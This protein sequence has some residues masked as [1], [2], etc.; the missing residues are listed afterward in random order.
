MNTRYI[1]AVD[2]GGSK[3]AVTLADGSGPLIRLSEPTA[4]SGTPRALGE[5]ALALVES[6]CRKSGVPIDAIE[7]L[8]VASCG[9]F[10]RCDG[11]ITLVTPNLCGAQPGAGDLPNDWVR[12]PLEQVL[13]ERF[14]KVE[15]RND[16]V[17]ALVAE[18][19]FGAVQDEPNCV[20]VTWSTGIGMG[21]CVDGRV[22]DGKHG[23]AGHGG[24]MLLTDRS[25]ALC[26]CGNRGDVES[27]ISGRNIGKHYGHSASA[28]FAAAREG[29]AEDRAEAVQ[30]A[31]WFGRALYNMIAILDTQSFV[32]GGSVWLHHG[33][34]LLPFVREEIDH[35]LLTLTKNVS[36]V[37][38]ALGTLVADIGGLCLVMPPAWVPSWRSD[39]PWQKLGTS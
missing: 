19:T 23:N 11:M 32:V 36:I 38:A 17:A 12:I 3:I 6:A 33:E 21:L 26:G 4:T 27:L 28:L 31:H 9:P 10:E 37:T 1:G 35:R 34:W 30:A 5:Q 15:I 18:R 13:R 29:K 22:L 14:R 25:D 7:E 16:C 24:H 20:Y 39:R 2:I 8:G